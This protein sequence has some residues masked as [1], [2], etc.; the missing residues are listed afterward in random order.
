MCEHDRV[1][2]HVSTFVCVYAFV[3]FNVCACELIYVFAVEFVCM[4]GL[5]RF[6]LERPLCI[7][8]CYF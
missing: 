5:A 6:V 7:L 4:C 8:Y 2:V 1:N 3:R